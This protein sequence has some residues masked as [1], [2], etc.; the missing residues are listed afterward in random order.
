MINS[1]DSIIFAG[2]SFLCFYLLSVSIKKYFQCLR[3]NTAVGTS[4]HQK[5]IRK[6]SVMSF[7]NIFH[8]SYQHCEKFSSNNILIS[9]VAVRLCFTIE[10]ICSSKL[11]YQNKKNEIILTFKKKCRILTR[12]C[13]YSSLFE[14][15]SYKK[16]NF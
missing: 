14:F 15:L 13:M 12:T 4:F 11:K 1:I 3:Q 16:I 6:R 7:F 5:Y 8:I 9:P 10:D 2:Q